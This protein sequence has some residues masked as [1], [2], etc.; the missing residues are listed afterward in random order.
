MLNNENVI[1]IGQG[2]DVDMRD[3]FNSYP[4]LLVTEVIDPPPPLVS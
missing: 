3:I 4:E 2:L 1:K